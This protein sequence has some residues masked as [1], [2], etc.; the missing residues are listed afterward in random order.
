MRVVLRLRN[1]QLV[2]FLLLGPYPFHGRLYDRFEHVSLACE[3]SRNVWGD[4]RSG[5]TWRR[6]RV[7][8]AYGVVVKVL[9]VKVET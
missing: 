8:L 3:T 1:V 9:G 5:E 6:R 7:R 4:A 2:V